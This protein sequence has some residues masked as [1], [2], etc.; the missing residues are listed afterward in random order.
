M[1]ANAKGLK[2]I[3]YVLTLSKAD[4]EARVQSLTEELLCL[5][6]NHEEEINSLQCQLG[7]R[8]NMEVTAAFSIQGLIYNLEA[9]VADIRGA[10]ERKNQECQ[11]LLDIK[12]RL[13]YEITTYHSLLESLDGR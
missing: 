12:S 10:L 1:E 2:Q 9:Q 3:L 5:K 13:E 4:L 8:I 6:T 7:D 11:V